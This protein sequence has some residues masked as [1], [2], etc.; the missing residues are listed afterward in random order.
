[1]NQDE[2]LID[3]CEREN[4]P[5]V[6]KYLSKESIDVNFRKIIILLLIGFYF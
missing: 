1:M 6:I 4:I 5:D 3:A 2:L